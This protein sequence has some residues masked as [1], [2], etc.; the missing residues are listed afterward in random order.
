VDS[1]GNLFISTS[2]FDD[3]AIYGYTEERIRKVSSDGIIT[4]VAGTGIGGFSGDGSLALNAQLTWPGSITV[5]R[6]GNLYFA[7]TGNEVVRILRPIGQPVWVSAVVDAASQKATPVS[8]G[9]LLIIYGSGLGPAQLVSQANQL[10]AELEETTVSFNGIPAQIVYSSTTQIA[11]VA[12]YTLTGT[13]AQITVAYRGEASQE[14]SVP[15]ALS[16]PGLF[17]A[18]HTGTGQAAALN[19]DGSVN[20]AVNPANIGESITLYATGEGLF[21]IPDP[22]F[23]KACDSLLHPILPVSVS[24][25]EIS[26]AIQC[27][28]RRPGDA[29]MQVTVQIPNGV[30]PGGYVPVALKVGNSSTTP[31]ALWIA[32]STN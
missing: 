20:S 24:V 11:A 1:T 3:G 12:P 29:V 16:S 32:V 5:D 19:S 15:I 27:A 18:N 17:T 26:A 10:T 25:G 14:F 22:P 2:S 4:T 13:T 28:G 30:Q 7:D 23:L 31:G 21:S 6:A 9:K 8:A